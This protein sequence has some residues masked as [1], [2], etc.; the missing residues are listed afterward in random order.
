MAKATL[1]GINYAPE[2]SGNAP[3]TTALAEHLIGSG[4]AVD[5][6]TGL[7]HY[8]SWERQ[9][10][11]PRSTL[12]GVSVF[13]HRHVVPSGSSTLGRA[14]MEATWSASSMTA[15]ASGSDTDVVVGVV[16]TL[17]GATTALAA[18]RRW[19]VPSVLWFQDLLGPS[20]EQSGVT[21][22]S[23]VA[24]TVGAI[25][26]RLARR[27]D[28][29]LVVADGFRTYF[30]TAGVAGERI[31]VIRNWPHVPKEPVDRDRAR[32]HFGF[33]TEDVVAVHSGNIGAKQ[34]LEVVTAGASLAPDVRFVVQGDGSERSSLESSVRARG[35]TNVEFLPSLNSSE[36]VKLL[37]AAD[38]L[39]LTQR[40]TVTDMSLPS[41]LTNYLTVG[42]P[43]VASINARSEAALLLGESGG[44]SVVEAGNPTTLVSAI[45]ASVGNPAPSANTSQLFGSPAQIERLLTR[46]MKGY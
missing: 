14:A 26:T 31:E 5:V 28:A 32:Q 16:P 13:R 2:P 8:P 3:Y 11:P 21:G 23:R 44:A 25:E 22:G 33:A 34:G 45:R 15:L 17:S 20:A 35:L 19:G 7:P 46:T 29:L 36:L 27:A 24:G 40:P 4:W 10:A 6:H 42:T 30:E 37:T 12:N 1:F 9:D 43:I 38:V 18:A 41:K 39:L